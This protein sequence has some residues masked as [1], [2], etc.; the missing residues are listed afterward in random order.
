MNRNFLITNFVSD[1]ASTGRYAGLIVYGAE[2][3]RSIASVA[4]P[5]IPE[6]S[7]VRFCGGIRKTKML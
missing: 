3:Y 5:V 7:P 1:A 4:L 2:S 6:W